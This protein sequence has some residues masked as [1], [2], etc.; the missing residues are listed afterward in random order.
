[1]RKEKIIF[2]GTSSFA[3]PALENLIQEYQILAV[4]TA[5]DRPTPSPVKEIA[6]KYNLDILQP[7]KIS[8][9][10]E[11]MTK[12]KPD[13]FIVASYGQI[14]P[15]DILEIPKKNSL[16][17]HPSLLPKYRGPSP[18]QTAI[19]NGDKTTGLTIIQMNEKMDAGP[20]IA[21]KETKINP[22]DTFQSLE[23]RLAE[24][25]ADLIIIILPRY[26][27]NKIKPQIQDESQVSYTKILTRDD[28]RINL[29][30][31]PQEIEKKV[32]AFYPW[33]GTWTEINNQRVKILK[34]K[35]KN[36][37][38]SLELVQPA[39]K[40]SMTGEAFYRGHNVRSDL[41]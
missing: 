38:I 25:I 41:Y 13:L 2:I 36:N 5:P 32:R 11:E 22:D 20:I 10:K 29:D 1:M 24:E 12:L 28:G 23:T 33:P 39:G 15:K 7:E 6:L 21:Q 37:K 4:V 9:I 19:L 27:K 26:F 40:K 34:V 35:I 8:D 3:L 16:N 18:I 31:N 17:L 30:E 14:I